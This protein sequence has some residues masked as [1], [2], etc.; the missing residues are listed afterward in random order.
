MHKVPE[1]IFTYC[2]YY[3]EITY[4]KILILIVNN[5]MQ[6]HK[7]KDF[8]MELKKGSFDKKAK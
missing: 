4:V 5:I 6:M 3:H 1:I 7:D 8:A 2:K